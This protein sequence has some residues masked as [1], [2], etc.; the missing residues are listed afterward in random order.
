MIKTTLGIFCILFFFSCKQ[1]Q[2]F[3]LNH[4]NNTYPGYK[5]SLI[6]THELD[7]GY[8][9]FDKLTQIAFD[10]KAAS[11]D[12]KRDAN[13]ILTD[14]TAMLNWSTNLG[15]DLQKNDSLMQRLI[16]EANAEI[17]NFKK[18]KL[19]KSDPS[20]K[21]V[22]V[23]FTINNDTIRDTYYI[24]TAQDKVC[25]SMSDINACIRQI[26]SLAIQWSDIY[27][28]TNDDFLIFLVD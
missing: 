2:S 23:I 5:V 1:K 20:K 25:Y 6:S 19:D 17:R 28:S 15:Y 27:N 4:L 16:N 12:F 14:D 3:L 7:S 22:E 10:L 13:H 21:A 8:T 26:D 9:R 11:E 24:N 18:V